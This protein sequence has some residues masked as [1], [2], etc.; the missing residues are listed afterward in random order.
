[1]VA[2]ASSPLK[3]VDIGG[4]DVNGSYA[5][6]FGKPDFDYLAVDLEPGPGVGVV[7]DDPYALPFPDDAFDLV[8]SGQM[9]EHCEMF[10]L[11][12][13]EM[14]R[15]TKSDGYLFLIAPS[16]GPIHRHPVDC[17]RFY[18][19]AYRALAKYADCHL[20]DL[21]RD[22][23]G[24]WNDLVGIFSKTK[25]KAKRP[26]TSDDSAAKAIN[27]RFV[28]SRPP[29][30]LS[31]AQ[32]ESR[33]LDVLAMLHKELEPQS[34]L[35]IGVREGKSLA[36][37]DCEAVGVDPD[38]DVTA[39]LSEKAEIV[40]QTSD[41]FFGWKEHPILE[42][43]P[44]LVFIDGMHLFENVLRDF[45]HVE[46]IAGPHTLVVIDDVLPNL[47]EQATRERNTGA[48]AGDVWKI[49]DCLKRFRPDLQ[50]TL[51]NSWPTGLLVVGRLKPKNRMLWQKYNP[52]VGQY[53]HNDR[54][55]PETVL[56]RTGAISPN[57][58]EFLTILRSHKRA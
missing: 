12:F 13:A 38:P 58:E 16:S 19:D 4:A 6:L 55:P 40:R 21:W 33:Y 51:V 31:A 53:V 26:K 18:P 35:E 11:S 57:G 1:M 14:M 42:A 22:R 24:P 47:A 45:M 52:I 48:W 5:D 41:D 15:V 36:L 3:I 44:D 27:N 9:L 56:N 32:G 28:G 2:K 46:E 29:P 39:T 7:L 17:Y 50:L 20:V 10:W 23:R 54:P 43:Q 49:Y 34:Y 30:E 8:I 25:Q 37:A